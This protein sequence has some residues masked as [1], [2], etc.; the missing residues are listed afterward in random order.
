MAAA[1][2]AFHAAYADREGSGKDTPPGSPTSGSAPWWNGCSG[3]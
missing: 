3:A 1:K 2:D